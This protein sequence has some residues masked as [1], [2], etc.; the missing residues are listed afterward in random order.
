M[1]FNILMCKWIVTDIPI[2]PFRVEF[3]M[4]CQLCQCYYIL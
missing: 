1:S 4:S 3:S 2:G